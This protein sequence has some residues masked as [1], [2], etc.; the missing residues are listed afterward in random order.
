MNMRHKVRAVSRGSIAR[1]AV[2][3]AALLSVLSVP[4]PAASQGLPA[5]RKHENWG[6]ND[7]DWTADVQGWVAVQ[8]A[9]HPR[10]VFRK[11]DLA[12][13]KQRAETSEGQAILQRLRNLL[14]GKFTLWH[15]AGYGLLYQLTGDKQHAETARRL[16]EDVIDRRRKDEKDSRYGFTNPGSGGAMRAGPAIGA[17]GLAYDMNHDGWDDAF[18]RK[19]ALAIQENP[20]TSSIAAKG[21]IMPSCNHYGAAIGG[22]GVG[23]LAIRGDAGVDAKK[24]EHLLGRIITQARDEISIGYGDR[25]Y[26]FE[27]HQ[28]G[29]ISSNTGL[30]PFIQACRVAAGKDLVAKKDNARWLAARWIYEFAANPDG[31]YTNPQR[32]MYCRN[33]PRGGQWS[34]N[35]DFC[36][37]FGICPPEYV[38]ALRWVYDHQVEPGRDKTY[39]VLANPHHAI[40]ALVNW[41]L[42]VQEKNPQ[43][44]PDLFPR[45]LHDTAAGYVI[46]RN[47]WSDAGKDI[48]VSALLGT[49]PTHQN[50]RGMASGGSVYVYGKGLGGKADAYYRFPGIFYSACPIYTKFE[51]DGSG[52][53]S[54]LTYGEKLNKF[55]LDVTECSTKPTSLA[56]DFSGVSGAGLLLA[57]AG[58]M[59]GYQVEYWMDIKPTKVADMTGRDGYATKTTEVKLGGQKAYVMTLQEGPAPEVRQEGNK[60]MVGRRALTFDGVKIA[61]E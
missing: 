28:C 4:V 29:R 43:D 3:M 21:P 11:T 24:V 61:L 14:D 7:P 1:L 50:G 44:Q 25:G 45:V 17:I 30:V 9:E 57:M 13:L 52:V 23:L 22:V 19:V 32:G 46:F 40:Y 16:C 5:P 31:T 53:L 55:S 56:V 12:R 2:G 33:L 58:P 39:D 60:V 48:C 6:Y 35:G 47:G 10:L 20:F 27:G 15:P 36:Q 8:P 41:P 18:R 38:P 54:A 49:H 51:K 37:G 59:V 42:D 34:E 26:Y